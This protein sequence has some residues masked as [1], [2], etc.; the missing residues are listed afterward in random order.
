MLEAHA[1]NLSLSGG[2]NQEDH[3]L[4]PAQE[5]S[6]RK[7]ILKIPNTKKDW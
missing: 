1:Y 3:G 5:N 2:R 6:S 4:K 7:P